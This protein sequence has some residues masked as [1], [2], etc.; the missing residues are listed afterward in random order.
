VCVISSDTDP[1]IKGVHVSNQDATSFLASKLRGILLPPKEKVM[2]EADITMRLLEPSDEAILNEMLYHAIFVPTGGKP[3]HPDVVNT[4]ELKKYVEGF[5]QAGDVGYVAFK[6]S[7]SIGAAWLRLWTRE[8][9][10]YG[11]VN[12][13]TPELTVAVVPTWAGVRNG[14][15]RASF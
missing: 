15:A 3:P 11:Y 2:N 14:F 12:D 5:G 9:K 10:G 4:L 7:E 8:N 13:E 1:L 6:C